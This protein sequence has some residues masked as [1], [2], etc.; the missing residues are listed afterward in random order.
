MKETWLLD[1]VTELKINYHCV[2]D[3]LRLQRSIT[4]GIHNHH[5]QMHKKWPNTFRSL[6]LP[7]MR[8]LQVYT[9]KNNFRWKICHNNTMRKF[10]KQSIRP[11]RWSQDL[12]L[13]E[14][15][16]SKK[17]YASTFGTELLIIQK[18]MWCWNRIYF[19]DCCSFYLHCMRSPCMRPFISSFALW[20]SSS[21]DALSVNSLRTWEF[22][23]WIIE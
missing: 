23:D 2:L 11:T 3:L 5:Y 17:L 18:N 1:C 21:Y 14:E 9:L 15:L 6:T 22:V 10:I 4:L 13:L 12:G 19:S 7:S 8:F 16:T 20:S